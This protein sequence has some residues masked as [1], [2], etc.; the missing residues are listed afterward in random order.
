M[1]SR[2]V[3]LALLL[4]LLGG[5]VAAAATGEQPRLLV[6][7]VRASDEAG[8]LVTVTAKGTG[9][10]S[11]LRSRPDL[12]RGLSAGEAPSWSPDGRFVAFS[13]K[14]GIWLVGA[15]GSDARRIPGTR[16]GYLPVFSPD[17]RTLAFARWRKS[18]L[19]DPIFGSSAIW[20]VDIETGKQRRLTALRDELEQFPASFSPDGS[21]LLATRISGGRS[22][23]F[24]LVAIRFDGRT[25]E[26]L[27][28]RGG[29]GKYSP[30]GNRIV[31]MRYEES[32]KEAWDLYT[33]DANGD[34]LRR[35]TDTPRIEEIDPTW[36]PSG[37]RI[38]YTRATTNRQSSILTATIWQANRDG[39]CARE[40]VARPGQ[41]LFTPSFE[42]GLGRA[43]GPLS[44]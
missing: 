22:F 32:G 8:D 3:S 29:F 43:A 17:G 10:R 4:A 25:S 31:F 11:L 37:Q 23:D 41:W 9:E 42:P 36:H 34:N 19:K 20:L 13:S 27:V 21:T 7:K 1:L 18:R 26:L 16:G 2:V 39:S 33:V 12:R 14:R 24:E 40:Y 35:L 38:V 30:D 6:S 28:G 5:S 15:D 44:C